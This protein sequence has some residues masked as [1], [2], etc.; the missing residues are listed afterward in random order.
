M[1]N[2]ENYIISPKNSQT[3]IWSMI[4]GIISFVCLGLAAIPA[5][6]CGH[7]A[8]GNINKSNGM[9]IGKGMS[10]AGLILGYA[11]IIIII[12]ILLVVT[13]MPKFLKAKRNPKSIVRS[14]QVTMRQIESAREQYILDG[15][16][17]LNVNSINGMKSVLV[18]DYFRVWPVCPSGGSFYWDKTSGNVTAI[19]D[20]FNYGQ[21]FT[22][23]E[24]VP[25]N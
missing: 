24:T 13:A 12:V 8:I 16:S 5:I 19:I 22:A 17:K 10:I 4:L 18:P 14:A 20:S 25:I 11:N 15:G 9:L 23:Y 2:S 3:A 7:I 21:P 1:V 6:I